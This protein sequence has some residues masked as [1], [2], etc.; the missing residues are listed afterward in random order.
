[1]LYV[2]ENNPNKSA[3]V[4]FA[5]RYLRIAPMYYLCTFIFVLLG[6]ADIKSI[7]QVIQTVT[8]LKYYETSPLLSIGWT[9]EFEFIFYGLCAFSLVLFRKFY[10]RVYLILVFLIT[11]VIII[12]FSIYTDKKYGHFAEFSF[13]MVVY[14]LYRKGYLDGDKVYLGFCGILVSILLFCLA[15]LFYSSGFYYL[16]FIGFGLPSCILLASVLHVRHLLHYSSI[17]DYLGDASYSIYIT[18]TITIFSCY[19]LLASNRGDSLFF[20]ILIFGLA[21]L[22]GCIAFSHIERPI[23]R[24]INHWRKAKVEVR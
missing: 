17:L 10:S 6:Y 7:H 20:D 9:L 1:M 19:K 13:G 22:I 21:I 14:F 24:K 16:R 8:F 5:D 2:I 23:S 11:A 3:F 4:F 15:H 18:H 12:D